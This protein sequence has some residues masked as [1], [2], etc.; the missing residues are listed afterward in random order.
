[1]PIADILLTI[2]WFGVL[3]G[4]VGS[5]LWSS[6]VILA[7]GRNPWW[8]GLLLV[9]IAWVFI[10]GIAFTPAKP[11]SHWYYTRY[12]D[13]GKRA[14]IYKWY[15]GNDLDDALDKLDELER[16]HNST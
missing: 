2:F 7:K 10:Y 15:E 1:M 12:D 6:Y 8:L 3:I 5:V 14:S 11:Y 9:P 13:A 16:T 4:F